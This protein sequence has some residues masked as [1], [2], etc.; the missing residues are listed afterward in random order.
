MRGIATTLAGR[1]SLVM[2]YQVRMLVVGLVLA[3]GGSIVGAANAADMSRWAASYDSTTKTRFIPIE[4]WTGGEW[5]GRHELR[6]TPANLSFGRR[7]EKRITGPVVWTR[8]G[9]TEA[10]QVYERH[11]K[12]KTQ[13]FALSSRGDGLGRVFDSRYRR[14]CVDEVKF[15]LGFWKDGETRVFDVSCNNGT[16]RRKIELTIEKIDFVYDGVPHSLQFHWVVNPGKGPGTDVRYIYCPGRGL[17][18]LDEDG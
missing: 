1:P 11:N 16:L 17:A 10:I 9:T 13:L 5:D 6:M 15:P 14:N 8:P 3:V 12:G 7:G 2:S 4:L 18:S